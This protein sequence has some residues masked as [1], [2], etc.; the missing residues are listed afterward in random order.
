MAPPKSVLDKIEHAVR[1]LADPTGTS[2]PA[3]LKF[4]KK[5]FDL[6]NAAVI[7]KAL[8]KGVDSGKLLQKGQSFALPGTKFESP[9]GARVEIEELA[10]GDKNGKVCSI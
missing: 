9:A 1:T 4:L 2:R 3:L 8:K 10:P 6:D 5:E 7:K